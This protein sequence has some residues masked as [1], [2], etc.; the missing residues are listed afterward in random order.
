MNQ[1]FVP[2]AQFQVINLINGDQAFIDTDCF[3]E[4]ASFD[5]HLSGSGYAASGKTGQLMHHSVIG[6]VDKSKYEIHHI[7]GNKL[8]NRRSN[9]KVLTFSEHLS[10]R[11]KQS[12]NTSGYKGVYWKKPVGK[13]KGAWVAQIG[14][15]EDGYKTR[16]YI[17]RY[18]SAELAAQAYDEA[19]IKLFGTN[20]LLN[21]PK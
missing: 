7:N 8:D 10:T 12:N 19:A 18:T 3:E 4:I 14:G 16:I 2:G 6:Y 9:L 15:S 17:G 13:R 11:P 5:W 21:F 1:T 20:A